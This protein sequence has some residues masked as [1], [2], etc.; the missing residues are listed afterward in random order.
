VAKKW[1]IF[2][3]N[4]GNS[5]ISIYNASLFKQVFRKIVIPAKAGI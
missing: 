4:P 5:E 1:G 3:K 2:F